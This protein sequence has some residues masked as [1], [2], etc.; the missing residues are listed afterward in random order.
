M[1]YLNNGIYLNEGAE[2]LDK[3]L[4]QYAN[5]S[6]VLF[7]GAQSYRAVEDFI[8]RFIGKCEVVEYVVHGP[9]PCEDTIKKAIKVVNKVRPAVILAVGGGK[10]IDTAKLTR[11]MYCN[12]LSLRQLL[13]SSGRD[14]SNSTPLAVVPTT[15]GTGAEVTQ[16]AVVYLGN[17]KCSVD[18]KAILPDYAVIDGQF[19]KGSS[20]YT[21]SCSLF[22]SFSQAIESYWS[23]NSTN[24]SKIYSR[25]SIRG[26]VKN[27]KNFDGDVL[28]LNMSEMAEASY[29]SGRAINITRTTAP[30]AMSYTLTTHYKIPHGHAVAL[31]MPFF[32][33]INCGANDANVADPR[34]RQYLHVIMCEIF[35]MIGCD[36][37]ENCQIWWREMM[38][39]FGLNTDFNELGILGENDIECVINNI[40]E[41]RL[42]NHPVRINDEKFIDS[43]R[44][45][46]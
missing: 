26:L 3:I 32:F 45:F 42:G 7:R 39:K 19:V 30:H 8:L 20:I 46:I 2:P 6:I 28:S 13:T 23:V 22:D 12:N 40:D 31:L 18:N 1:S 24:E 38:E 15:A 37:A 27:I 16:F 10:V 17:V 21:V 33:G 44:C 25:M 14:L 35:Y 4:S 11:V 41:A 29:Y 5:N 9:Y 43:L 36:T 34:G